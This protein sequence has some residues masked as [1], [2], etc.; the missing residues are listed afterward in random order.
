MTHYTLTI[1][2]LCC[3]LPLGARADEYRERVD[4]VPGGTL[5]IDL[6]AG[7]VEVETG[8]DD[9]V[10]VEARVTGFGA[11]AVRFRLSSD[12]R[13][14]TFVGSSGGW[15]LGILGGPRIR[16]VARVPER[17][18]VRVETGGG[19]I[20]IEEIDGE[21]DAR[22]S[23]GGIAVD[24]TTGDVRLRTSGGR[25]QAENIEGDLDA[26]TSGGEIRVSDVKGSVEVKTSGGWIQIDG[27]GGL[28]RAATSG[29]SISV[30]FDGLP[31]GSIQT[32]GGGI[33]V[34]IPEGVG[35]DLDAQTSGGRVVVRA[36]VMPSSLISRSQL[37]GSLN[38]GGAPLLLRTS[39][40]N[41]SVEER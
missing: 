36:E 30:R 7:S 18:S 27:A 8:D 11:G 23:G 26:R 35:I 15:T 20:E 12:G 39:G 21:I 19:K 37:K 14:A 40:G 17:Y 1:A 25:I 16:V 31:E 6:A 22:T 2:L 41:I 10:R 4:V 29:G 32:S 28:V 3:A 24:G 38:G 5:A 34:E 9:E 13:D 33:D